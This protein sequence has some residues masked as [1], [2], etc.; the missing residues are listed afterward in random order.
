[1]FIGHFAI[2]LLARKQGH[3]PSLALMFIAVQFLDL[4]WPV[5]VLLGVESLSID[6]GNT[7]LTPLNFEHYPYSHSLFMAIVWSVLF[8][9]TYYLVRKNGK[10]ALLLGG[11]VI[12]H[13]MLDLIT[14]RP[15]LPLSPFAETKVGLGLWNVPAAAIPFEVALFAVGTYGYLKYSGTI[16]KTSFWIL[17][18]FLVLI[19]FMNLFGPPP[20]NTMAVAWSANLMWLIVLWA[21]WIERKKTQVQHT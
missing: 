12:S 18:G 19:Y 5:L 2:G 1:M 8:G 10:G 4:L 15:D 20:P 11:L 21:W 17:A 14:H 6:P 13:W 9:L 7:A 3:L 16:R